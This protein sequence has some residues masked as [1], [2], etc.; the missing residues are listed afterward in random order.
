M[1]IVVIIPTYNEKENM[2]RMIPVLEKEVFLKVNNHEM[3]ILVADD[4]SPDGTAEVVERYMKE[5][6]NIH[7]LEGIKEGLGV[8]Y[9]RAMRYAM[10]KMQAGAVIEFDADFQH[11]PNDIPRLIAAMDEGYDYVI[12]S[13]Y[14]KGG[15]VPANWGFHRKFLSKVGSLVARIVWWNFSIH[16]MTAG[17]K[18]TKTE[19]LKKVDLEHLYSKYFAYKLHILHDVVKLGAKVKEIPVDF[20]DREIGA[21]KISQKESLE[22]LYVVLRLRFDDSK[23][24]ISFLF[25]GGTGFI[26]Q[27]AATAISIR[28]GFAQ[29]IATMI[30]AEIAILSNFLLNNAW[31]FGDTKKLKQQGGFLARL[32]K[33]NIASLAS[34][35]I[36]GLVVYLA[37]GA[38][39][40]NLLILG[41]SL[42]TSIAILFPTIIFIVLPLNYIIYN[43]IIWKTQYLKD[44]PIKE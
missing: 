35:G 42:H 30:G 5:Y 2:E 18:L 16:D 39:G 21:S 19:Y 31:T 12:G 17:L 33:F 6:K 29:Y 24:V 44:N 1:K 37:V 3:Q 38:L 25:V 36:Q 4:K 40:E 9:A 7:L 28:L 23:R 32:L 10:D 13:R 15:S 43:K 11:D 22:S 20:H 41:Y 34:I 27:V 26:I 8:A 14:I